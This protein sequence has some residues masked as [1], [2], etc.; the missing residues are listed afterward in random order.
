[1]SGA[2]DQP[3][4]IYVAWKVAGCLFGAIGI[5]VSILGIPIAIYHGVTTS[6]WTWLA[7]VGVFTAVLVVG[8]RSGWIESLND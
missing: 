5:W 7:A 8:F 3:S 1:M 6:D 2:S 4:N